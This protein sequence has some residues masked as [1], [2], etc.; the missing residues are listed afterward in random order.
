MNKNKNKNIKSSQKEENVNV[1]RVRQLDET[2]TNKNNKKEKPSVVSRSARMMDFSQFLKNFQNFSTNLI[3]F[4]KKIKIVE[5]PTGGIYK[6][7]NRKLNI[8]SYPDYFEV[9]SYNDHVYAIK[10]KK[11][12]EYEYPIKLTYRE[13]KAFQSIAYREEYKNMNTTGF[14]NEQ[15]HFYESRN[16]Y[17]DD[18]AAGKPWS[19]WYGADPRSKEQVTLIWNRIRG[20]A[21]DDKVAHVDYGSLFTWEGKIVVKIDT[22]WNITLSFR[23]EDGWLP[24]NKQ[25]IY[26]S[27]RMYRRELTWSSKYVDRAT[28][29]APPNN[30]DGFE[31]ESVYTDEYNEK[32]RVIRKIPRVWCYTMGDDRV[33]SDGG[34][35]MD[36]VYNRGL[37]YY[38]GPISKSADKNNSDINYCTIANGKGTNLNCLQ[39]MGR[40]VYISTINDSYNISDQTVYV[41]KSGAG[42]SIVDFDAHIVGYYGGNKQSDQDIKVEFSFNYLPKIEQEQTLLYPTIVICLPGSFSWR[43]VSDKSLHAFYYPPQ[44]LPYNVQRTIVGNYNTY[45][46]SVEFKTDLKKILV[47]DVGMGGYPEDMLMAMITDS[48]GPISFEVTSDTYYGNMTR[49]P[50]YNLFQDSIF[51]IFSI[52]VFSDNFFGLTIPDPS[53]GTFTLKITQEATSIYAK[54]DIIVKFEWSCKNKENIFRPEFTFTRKETTIN[55]IDSPMD[56]YNP[57][58]KSTTQS[59]GKDN[60]VGADDAETELEVTSVTNRKQPILNGTCFL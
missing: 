48:T 51:S 56:V 8:S 52:K 41:S 60:D 5:Q 44:Q 42:K 30:V 1:R 43:Y 6:D 15:L 9:S 20:G 32:L 50:E 19:V 36:R 29:Y 22:K 25:W 16:K 57:K 34:G 23:T 28:Y 46:R 45:D 10:I 31:N 17:I 3:N 54:R 11:E 18:I 7:V 39:G 14:N 47:D 53:G 33:C 24:D 58:V 26:G 12:F 37:P 27:L 40:Y 55:V 35:G 4:T 21:L 38:Y 49:P 59:V 2:N 13:I